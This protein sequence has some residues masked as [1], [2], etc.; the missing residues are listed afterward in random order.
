MRI[1]LNGEATE[2]RATR[3]AAAL[4]ELGYEGVT[5]ATAVNES[6]VPVAGRDTTELR[7]GDRVEVLAPRQGG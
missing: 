5:V 4:H 3:L 6:F 1:F 7:D 2:V